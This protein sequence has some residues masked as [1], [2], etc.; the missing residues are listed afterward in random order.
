VAAE[1]YRDLGIFAGT[2]RARQ[3]SFGIVSIFPQKNQVYHTH[4]LCI[5]WS[6][7]SI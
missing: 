3:R 6:H 4:K 2:T 1:E 7:L 5:K